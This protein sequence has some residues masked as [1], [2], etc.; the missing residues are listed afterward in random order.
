MS[1]LQYA[2]LLG[3]F[4]G[5]ILLVGVYLFEGR[6]FSKTGNDKY[7]ILRYFPFE[8]NCFKRN[9]KASYIY[10]VVQLIGT[11][12]ISSC[13]LFFAIETWHNGGALII[14]FILFAISFLT[15][16]T[17]NALTFIK[18]SNYQLHLIFAV[19]FVCLNLLQLVLSLFFLTNANYYFVNPTHQ[20][21]QITVFIIIFIILIFEAV[22]MFNPSYKRWNKMVKVDAE[23]FN[24]PRFNYLAMLEWG[25]LI[26]YVLNLIPLGVM[27]YF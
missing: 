22:L 18:L 11:L 17:Y 12:L 20:G 3:A 6:S 27:M 21:T 2:F 4:L 24:R 13:F 23:T 8:I 10:P 5:I 26:I 15:A 14:S 7:N 1:E 9:N 19:I 16:L 25:N